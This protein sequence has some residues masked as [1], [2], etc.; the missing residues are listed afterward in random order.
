MQL[1]SG[2]R[3]ML[4]MAHL[5]TRRMST[6]LT[7][8]V[9]LAC[10]A[11]GGPA[12]AASYEVPRDTARVDVDDGTEKRSA[13]SLGSHAQLVMV[14]P[15]L[16]TLLCYL[17][18]H[19][20]VT[21]T[22]QWDA[23]AP[24]PHV[25]EPTR[26]KGVGHL[27]RGFVAQIGVELAAGRHVLQLESPGC[28]LVLEGATEAAE[29]VPPSGGARTR[30]VQAQLVGATPP[31]DAPLVASAP[32][33]AEP[34]TPARILVGARLG[35]IVPRTELGSGFAASAEV[36]YLLPV[37]DQRLRVELDVGY[38]FTTFQGPRIV[39]GRGYDASFTQNT[40]LV[41]IDLGAFFEQPIGST[42]FSVYGGVALA[43]VVV[44][45]SFQSFD[46][47]S[48]ASD[49]AWGPLFAGGAAYRLGPG[50]V[51]LDVRYTEATANL[52]PMGIEGQQALGN[53][54]LTAGYVVRL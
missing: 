12:R 48:S 23:H 37:L 10:A 16:V 28:A 30:T 43:M 54:Q 15:G 18:H 40:T 38:G 3:R 51:A 25:V 5:R 26:V 20:K 9:V 2:A 35:A 41:P 17:P 24:V 21:L 34:G 29:E 33:L 4:P 42:G 39:P 27:A 32:S 50:A 53:F 46:A 47:K 52:G 31:E 49:V 11:V 22:T 8:V 1:L 13:L 45:A 14:G 6:R 19:A 44:D 7:A 36:G